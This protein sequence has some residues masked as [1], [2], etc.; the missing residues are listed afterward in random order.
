MEKLEQALVQGE[1]MDVNISNN[2][3]NIDKP[4]DAD[5]SGDKVSRKPYFYIAN[6]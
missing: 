2:S 5:V 3:E 4:D 1:T 6:A